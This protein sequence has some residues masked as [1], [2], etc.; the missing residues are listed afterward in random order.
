MAT[1]LNQ[2]IDEYN[3]AIKKQVNVR[4]G[5]LEDLFGGSSG[6]RIESAEF[7]VF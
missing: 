6:S 1:A 4:A 7:E 3:S 5:F 2:T